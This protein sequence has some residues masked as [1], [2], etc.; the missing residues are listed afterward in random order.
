MADLE[1]EG[2]NNSKSTTYLV[3][4]KGDHGPD[5]LE[6]FDGANIIEVKPNPDLLNGNFHH[7][8]IYALGAGD[9][10]GVLGTSETGV[11]VKG[12][13]S[14]Y[15][16]LLGTGRPGVRGEGSIGVQGVDVSGANGTGVQG[17]G[18]IGV[19]GTSKA[20]GGQGVRGEGPIAIY[21]KGTG[22]QSE[23]VHGLGKTGVFGEG[24]RTGVR[25]KAE[26]GP[27]MNSW[28]TN[29]AGGIFEGGTIGI[30]CKGNSESG[31]DFE[32]RTAGITCKSS[33]GSGGV[34]EADA[35]GQIQLVP[36]QA[37]FSIDYGVPELPSNGRAGELI[38][39]TH[40]DG[41]CALYLCIRPPYRPQ[42]SHIVLP[43]SWAQIQ[44]GDAFPGLG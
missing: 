6:H 37:P 10:T 14:K 41:N 33:E 28:S 22:N 5:V 30:K 34:F 16:G 32:G 43:A 11:G 23:G 20:S 13:S 19:E 17:E 2:Y 9:G 29:A 44:L 27:G 35:R 15:A 3:G 1:L 8:A 36:S 40:E 38:A 12:T 25:A 26:T 39:I 4:R 7:N 21:G 18:Y 42:H 24:I 31:G